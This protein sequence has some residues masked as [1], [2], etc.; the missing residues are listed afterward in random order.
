[1]DLDCGRFAARDEGD[2]ASDT[3]L[4][5]SVLPGHPGFR[6]EMYPQYGK[7]LDIVRPLYDST[8]KMN[9]KQKIILKEMQK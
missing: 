1:M 8:N 9:L 6:M 7:A 3:A 5:V 2:A 4:W